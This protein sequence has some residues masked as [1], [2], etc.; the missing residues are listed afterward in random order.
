MGN[1]F[2]AAETDHARVSS[3]KTIH[4]ELLN[5]AIVHSG[6]P[7]RKNMN[8]EKWIPLE[9]ELPTADCK[10]Y[11][12]TKDKS[13]TLRVKEATYIAGE[14]LFIDRDT[15]YSL[16]LV[17]TAWMPRHVPKAYR[18]KS[19]QL[20]GQMSIKDIPGVVPKGGR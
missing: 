13:G 19:E 18:P 3:I 16:E 12:S 4:I 9:S 20:P 2:T 1:V 6:S 7:E 17:A 11:V 8:K 15:G 10:C 14:K 5:W